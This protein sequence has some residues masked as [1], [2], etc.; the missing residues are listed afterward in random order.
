MGGEF[1]LAGP[2]PTLPTQT[3]FFCSDAAG[4]RACVSLASMLAADTGHVPRVLSNRAHVGGSA[5][6][7]VERIDRAPSASDV[8]SAELVFCGTSHPKTS[9]RF[10]LAAIAAAREAGVRTVSFVDHWTSFRL[11]FELEG[12]ALVLP[13]EIWVLDN[14]AR[15]LA[16]EDGLPRER[17]RVTGSPTL[18]FLARAR[19][20]DGARAPSRTLVYAPDP[21]SHRAPPGISGFDEVSAAEDLAWALARAAREAS[22]VVRLHPLEPASSAARIVDAFATH[23]IAVRESRGGET[24]ETIALYRDARVV[25]GFYSN[26][27]L[28][29]RAV[30]ADILRYLPGAAANDPLRHLE[31]G[32]MATT[33]DE[34]TK[35]LSDCFR[36]REDAP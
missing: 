28:E 9:E 7:P 15:D 25:V 12:G 13:D 6:V 24:D 35:R 26:A 10:E 22:V 8:A 30:G 1:A 27:L 11:R 31:L 20:T 36:R 33:R 4:T 3:V 17:V 21:I 14:H 23:G 16:I 18:A 32:A 19:K 2:L 29:A 5:T 34:L